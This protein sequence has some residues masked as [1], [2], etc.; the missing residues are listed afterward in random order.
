[1]LPLCPW[2]SLDLFLFLFLFRFG[3]LLQFIA[4]LI[5]VY[6]AFAH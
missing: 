5:V 6:N 2:R 4:K 1:L 3:L